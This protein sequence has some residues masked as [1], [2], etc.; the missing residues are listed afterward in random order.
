MRVFGLT[1]GIGAGKS[2]VARVLRGVGIPVIDADAVARGQA[3]PGQPVH[4]AIVAEFGAGVV[5]PDGAIDRAALARVVFADP[6]R[7]ARLNGLTHPPVMAE[8]ARRLAVLAEGGHPLAVI[9]AALVFEAGLDAG[10]DGVA[11]VCAPLDARV[12]RVAARD[13][14]A[15]DAV[16]AR[17]AA[18]IDD[19]ARRARATWVIENDAGLPQLRA[20]AL[21]LAVDL[22]RGGT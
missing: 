11:V 5:G 14:T 10:C 9:E 16:R 12:A 6:S 1:G 20:R 8:V 7:L 21:R 19:D 2:E 13:G 3:L 17:V 22:V 15:P 4:D 18:Q